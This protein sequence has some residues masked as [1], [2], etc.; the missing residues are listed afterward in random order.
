[1]KAGLASL[2]LA[3]VALAANNS[4]AKKDTMLRAMSDEIAR[5]KNLQLNTLDRPYFIQY[6]S[7]DTHD[8]MIEASLGGVVRCSNVHVRRPG[9]LVRV[10]DYAF[11]NTNSVFFRQLRF[12]LFPLDD[13][14]LAMRTT[15]W[16]TTDVLY[17]TAVDQ[18]TRKRNVVR[19]ST[20]PDKTPDFARAATVQ[21]IEPIPGFH[22]DSAAW[23]RDAREAS[24]Q[25]ANSPSITTSGIKVQ[26]LSSTYRMVNSEG[27]V[28]RIPQ[29]LNEVQ[30]RAVAR[31]ADGRRVWNHELLTALDAKDLPKGKA[32]SQIADSV[33]KQTEALANAPVA[34]DYTGPV[35]FEGEAAAQMMAQVLTDAAVLRRKPLYPQGMDESG[36]ETVES[37]WSSRVQSSVV[38]EWMSIYD[39]PGARQARGVELAGAYPIDDE[40][41]PAQRV[42]LVDKGKLKGFL[43]SRMPV[44]T[45]Q[46]S[47]GH[48]RLPGAF[49]SEV[50]VLGN[51]FVETTQQVSEAQLKARML[52]KVK[53]AG[54]KYGIIL[55]RLDFP[56]TASLGELQSMARQLQRN[57]YGRTINQ[58]LLAYRV[59]PDGREELVRGFRFREFS[60]KDLRDI[61]AA[62]DQPYVF[63]YVNN[64]SS[65][66][67]VDLRNEAALS[68]V[69]C[70]SLLLDSIELAKA[71][72]EGDPAPLVPVPTLTAKK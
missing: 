21:V 72:N 48:G 18:I 14:Y 23:T 32:L 36:F 66:N 39:D 24:T 41:V 64:G 44:R 6:T 71:E 53:S 59:Y 15:L 50:P 16:R 31:A 57:G 4:D 28:V 51:A 65:L 11:D 47:N 43:L 56:S 25:F 35:I 12:G 46:G 45:F 22:D 7:D 37:V 38:P 29:V 10:G 13:D 27:S 30:V 1:M 8:L 70:P 17:K 52:E 68:S 40:G 49:G 58:P 2:L 3:A 69:I 67:I 26:I 63:N 61:A 9:A 19:E 33:A 60:A 62:S 42:Q 55:R 5:S 34:E 20:D 54:L